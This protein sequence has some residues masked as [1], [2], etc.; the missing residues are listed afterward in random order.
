MEIVPRCSNRARKKLFAGDVVIADSGNN[1][2]FFTIY[3]VSHQL[4]ATKVKSLL[5]L[6]M[7]FEA[8]LS[9]LKIT[10]TLCLYRLDRFWE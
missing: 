2:N 6:E 3:M 10:Q 5:D 7:H 1:S 9:F 8:R 4:L